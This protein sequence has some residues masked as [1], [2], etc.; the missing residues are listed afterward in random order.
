MI[1][2]KDPTA[3]S[4][5]QTIELYSNLSMSLDRFFAVFLVLSSFI[6]LIALYPL[7]LGLWPVMVIALFH[8]VMVGLC[9]RSAWRGNWAREVIHFGPETVTIEHLEARKRWSL[10]WPSDWLRVG[11]KPD[12][13]GELRVWLQRQAQATELGSFLP[14]EERHELFLLIKTMLAD[15]TAWS[16]QKQ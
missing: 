13:R 4:T 14:S 10:E 1:K 12:G 9:F 6:L 15:K 2:V 5:C 7:M 11:Q 16:N 8:V 3:D